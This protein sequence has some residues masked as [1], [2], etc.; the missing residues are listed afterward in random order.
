MNDAFIFI[1]GVIVT[2]IW[3]GAIG[4]LIWAAYQD[5]KAEDER[6]R[7]KSSKQNQ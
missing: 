7:R 6:K 1:A 5:G 4:G 3:S 2:L